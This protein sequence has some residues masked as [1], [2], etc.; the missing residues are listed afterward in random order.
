MNDKV[1][2]DN[3]PAMKPGLVRAV[4]T[5]LF[6][7]AVP[8]LLIAASVAWA[9]NDLG[10]YARG[11]DKYDIPTVT[12]IEREDLVQV[13]R[14]IRSY[15]HSTQEPLDVRTR[16]YG[17]EQVLFNYREVIHMADVKDLIWVVYGT[18]ALALLFMSGVGVVGFVR[19]GRSFAPALC[20]R[21]LW[22]AE[23]TVGLVALVG[24]ISLVAFDQL[25]LLFHRVSFANDFWQLD[26]RRDFLVM[27]FPEGFWLDATLF[28]AFLTLGGAALLAV[29]SGGYLVLGNPSMRQK[30]IGLLKM[31][32]RI[33]GKN[34]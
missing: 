21:I 3:L 26:P 18:G 30:L 20:R 28:V 23:A 2:S 32:A 6:V 24:L 27:M 34:K 12:G 5:L 22:G 25:F 9:V 31:D 10:L 11:F 14:E 1:G 17:R 4:V 7:V 19:K 13:G 8:V 15:F 16:I 29:V 33:R